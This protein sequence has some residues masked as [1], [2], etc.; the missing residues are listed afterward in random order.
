MTTA[1]REALVRLLN[2]Q[3]TTVKAPPETDTVWVSERRAD[4]SKWLYKI[5]REGK[6]GGPYKI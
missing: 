6:I 4:R 1:Q 2:N 5:D 3:V